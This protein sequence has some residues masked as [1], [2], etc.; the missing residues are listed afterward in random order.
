MFSTTAYVILDYALC[1]DSERE[2][3]VNRDEHHSI[4]NY[5]LFHF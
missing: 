3:F 2:A 5:V 4:A 1:S